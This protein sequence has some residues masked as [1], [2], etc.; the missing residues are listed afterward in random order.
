MMRT[1]LIDELESARRNLIEM[2]ETTVSLIAEPPSGCGPKSRP[3][4][5]DETDN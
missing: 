1:Y 4:Y 2:G 3:L 5:I